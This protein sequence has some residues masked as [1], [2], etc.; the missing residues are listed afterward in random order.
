M[1]EKEEERVRALEQYFD[2]RLSEVQQAGIRGM[3]SA[4]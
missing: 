2:L 1:F 4:I 3:V